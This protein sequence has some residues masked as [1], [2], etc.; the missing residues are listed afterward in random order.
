[1]FA[2]RCPVPVR[3]R[4]PHEAAFT[5]TGST[6][7]SDL[8]TEVVEEYGVLVLVHRWIREGMMLLCVNYCYCRYLRLFTDKMGKT[9]ITTLMWTPPLYTIIFQSY[10][11]NNECLLQVNMDI[12]TRRPRPSSACGLARIPP[13][14]SNPTPASLTHTKPFPPEFILLS[15][16]YR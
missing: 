4:P 13:P 6:F 1:M 12:P 11:R 16:T 2:G 8:R 7:I 15:S 14:M 9:S 5:G 10:N 3:R